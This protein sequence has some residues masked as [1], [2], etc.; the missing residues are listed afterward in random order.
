MKFKSDNPMRAVT[1]PLS[2]R[3][4]SP[5]RRAG[6]AQLFPLYKSCFQHTKELHQKVIIFAS[7]LHIMESVL[8]D[9]REAGFVA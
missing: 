9:F 8:L 6:R 2:I 3:P 5:W 7:K 1:S 4:K